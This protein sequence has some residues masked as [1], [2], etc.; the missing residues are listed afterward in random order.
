MSLG[1]VVVE[2]ELTND[3]AR[4]AI[5]ALFGISPDDVLIVN[6]L[7]DLLNRSEK[8]LVLCHQWWMPAGR[9][10]TVLSFHEG[11]FSSFLCL[12]T[13][14]KLSAHLGSCC[15]IADASSNPYS[16]TLV[17][18][19]GDLQPVLLDSEKLEQGQYEIV[20]S[21]AVNGGALAAS[22]PQSSKMG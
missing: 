4:K 21:A 15:L 17:S 22:V 11:Q 19:A 8:R 5:A 13:V 7:A 1:D 10:R 9:F 20:C 6:D 16:M 18:P 14:L 2:R 3:E 12:P